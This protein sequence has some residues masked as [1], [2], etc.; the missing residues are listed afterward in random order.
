MK[1]AIRLIEHNSE[2]YLLTVELR[3]RLLRKPLSLAF[4]REEL[5][6]ENSSHHV[7]A[8]LD[9]RLAGC[10]VLKPLEDASLKMRQVA[11][12]EELQGKGIGKAMVQFSEEFGRQRGYKRIVLHARDNAI[13]FYL[14]LNYEICSDYFEEVGLLHKA[15][16]KLL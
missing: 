5:A 2:E 1:T 12:S 3:D 13:P 16:F 9:K 4:S 11:V 15:M 8:F 10:L 6:A 14:K 7:G